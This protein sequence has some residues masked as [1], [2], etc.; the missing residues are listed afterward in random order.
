MLRTVSMEHECG[1][2]SAGPEDDRS[3]DMSLLRT[4]IEQAKG[5]VQRS[6]ALVAEIE[7]QQSAADPKASRA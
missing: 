2:A 5:R 7:R 4:L 6:R 1:S 3:E